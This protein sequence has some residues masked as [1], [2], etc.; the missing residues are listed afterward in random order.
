MRPG[1]LRPDRQRTI[2]RPFGWI[3]FRLMTSGLLEKLRP[4]AKLLYFFLCLVSDGRGVSFYGERRIGELLE[5]SASDLRE[6]RQQL[7]QNDLLAFDGRVYQLLSLPADEQTHLCETSRA[8]GG[9]Q[10]LDKIGEWL[11]HR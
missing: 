6:A 2:E 8:A 10:P 9:P 3:P 7:C 4:P 11:L 5:L 1:P